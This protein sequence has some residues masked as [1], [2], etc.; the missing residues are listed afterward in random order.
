M[1]NDVLGEVSRLHNVDPNNG[2]LQV[3][4]TPLDKS[5]K[6]DGKDVALKDDQRRT[7]Q[8]QIGQATQSEWSSIISSDKY[9][10]INDLDKANILSKARQDITEAEK[11]SFA[12]ANNLGDVG[13]MTKNARKYLKVKMSIGSTANLRATL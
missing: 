3:T 4:P 1:T 10:S 5:I 11:E 2:D 6:L 12:Q 8:K 13:K 9:K 7:L